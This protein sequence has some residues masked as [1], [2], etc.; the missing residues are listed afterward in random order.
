MSSQP[1]DDPKDYHGINLLKE[2]RSWSAKSPSAPDILVTFKS[3]CNSLIEMRS[4][5]SSKEDIS[6]EIPPKAGS[7]LIFKGLCPEATAEYLVI[8]GK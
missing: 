3:I 4:W 2:F 8:I 6:K 7:G 5:L 1:Y